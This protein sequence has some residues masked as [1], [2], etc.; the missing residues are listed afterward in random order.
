MTNSKKTSLGMFV[1]SVGMVE[2]LQQHCKHGGSFIDL[3]S[4]DGTVV[5]YARQFGV[6]AIGVEIDEELWRL[7]LNLW[8]REVFIKGDFMQINLEGFDFA[9]YYVQGTEK[10]VELAEKLN[11]EFRGLLLVHQGV[12]VQDSLLEFTKLLKIN[13]VVI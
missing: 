12:V 3:G 9:Y 4:G 8:P 2:A 11:R 5:R 10:E 1:Q 13:Y 6:N 7:S